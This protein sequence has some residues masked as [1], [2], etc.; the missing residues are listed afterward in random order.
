MNKKDIIYIYGFIKNKYDQRARIYSS[1]GEHSNIG[2]V[3]HLKSSEDKENYQLSVDRTTR[4]GKR[5]GMWIGVIAVLS[6]ISVIILIMVLSNRGKPIT[7]GG[8]NDD[9]GRWIE[10]TSD[11]GYIITGYTKPHTYGPGGFDLWLIKV[12]KNGHKEWERTFGGNYTDKG[13]SVQ[14]TPDKGYII[15]GLTESYGA[16]RTDLYLVKTDRDGNKEWDRTFGG[17]G[18]DVGYSLKQTMD[19]GYIITGW[20]DSYGAGS[21]DLWLIK[22]DKNGNKEWERTF[23]GNYTDKGYSV[24]ETYDRGFIIT[25]YT[26]SYGEGWADIWLIKVDRNGDKKWDRTFGGN[27]SDYGYSV[28]QTREQGYIITGES[29]GDLCLIKTDRDGNKEWERTFGG[30]YTDVG[31]SVKQTPDSGYIITGYTRSYGAGESDIWLIKVDKNGNKKWDRTFGG[32]YNDVGY[33]LEKTSEHGYIITGYTKS[34]GAGEKDLWLI[35][36][37]ENGKIIPNIMR[38]N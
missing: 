8:K 16:G 12:D 30:K 21:Y 18:Y 24:Q 23:G 25:G 31:Y 35:K 13:Y 9:V 28:Q 33:S 19:G 6:I 20:T 26:K 29:N 4:E 15:T 1:P 5:G 14:Q 27:W 22:V 2:R 32:E 7:F 37:D 10:Q 38:V 3:E 11:R 17:E 36:T 34:Y